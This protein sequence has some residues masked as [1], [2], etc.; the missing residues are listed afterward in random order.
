MAA[1]QALTEIL[2]RVHSSNL[3]FSVNLTPYSA[4]ITVRKSFIKNLPQG[5]LQ[6][7]STLN[8]D[9]KLKNTQFKEERNHLFVQMNN[10]NDEAKASKDTINILEEKV[11]KSEASALNYL[12]KGI[13]RLAT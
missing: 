5:N 3:N 6:K 10:L 9:L 7:V 1:D 12:R 13:L 11:S 4:Y 2:Q 8:D